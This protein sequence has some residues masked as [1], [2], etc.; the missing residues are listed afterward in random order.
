MV[1]DY[2]IS[3]DFLMVVQYNFRQGAESWLIEIY[4]YFCLPMSEKL[5]HSIISIS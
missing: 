5:K 3:V 2:Q 1:L 4:L